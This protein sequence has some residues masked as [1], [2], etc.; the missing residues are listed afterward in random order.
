MRGFETLRSGVGRGG[1]FVCFLCFWSFLSFVWHLFCFFGLFDAFCL[2]VVSFFGGEGGG[3][4]LSLLLVG[5]L[6]CLFCRV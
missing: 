1:A 2:I 5:L 3:E 4:W 6:L